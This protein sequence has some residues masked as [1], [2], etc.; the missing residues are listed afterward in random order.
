[1]KHV[2]KIGT[3]LV[4]GLALTVGS[5]ATVADAATK[6]ASVIS[7]TKIAKA[8]YHGRRG[9]I[10]SSK[11]LTKVR[12]RMTKYKYTTWYATQRAT[13]KKN[14]KKIS[15][16]YIKAGSKKG[17]ISSQYLTSGKAPVNKA[18]IMANDMSSVRKICISGS[19]KLQS[20]IN[21]SSDYESLSR[22]INYYYE[23]GT[24]YGD[25]EFSDMKKDKD[26][27][28]NIYDL[29]KNRLPGT[30]LQKKNLQAMEKTV[31]S[32]PVDDDSSVAQVRIFVTQ[33]TELLSAM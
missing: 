32:A 24:N 4:L 20:Y 29:F 5:T 10:Y 11:K 21:G 9:N 14:G 18:K 30:S 25:L 3:M 1:M 23:W 8:A 2:V 31:D 22:Q 17:W 27:L 16:T 19:S 33:F 26:A 6:K 7:T 15:L 13:V 12:Y 28:L